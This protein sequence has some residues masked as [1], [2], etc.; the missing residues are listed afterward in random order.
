M[1]QDEMMLVPVEPT[2]AQIEAFR[3]WYFK[4][5]GKRIFAR[6]ATKAIQTALSAAPAQPAAVEGAGEPVAWRWHHHSQPERWQ[7]TTDDAVTHDLYCVSEPLYAHPSPPADD[8]LR[9]A[10]E[11]LMKLPELE[12]WQAQLSKGIGTAT[13]DG[14]VVLAVLAALKAGGVK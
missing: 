13:E 5:T 4:H 2:E 7:V 3:D 9:V 1:A 8:A 14:K 11:A 6:N 12:R 10:V